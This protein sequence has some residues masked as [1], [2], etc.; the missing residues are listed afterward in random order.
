MDGERATRH[1]Y[2]DASAP[3]YANRRSPGC[4]TPAMPCFSPIHHSTRCRTGCR[5]SIGTTNNQCSVLSLDFHPLSHRLTTA[6]VDHDVKKLKDAIAMHNTALCSIG[7]PIG[8]GDVGV[9]GIFHSLH[10]KIVMGTSL[11]ISA[12][13][14]AIM[15]GLVTK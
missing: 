2:I 14:C 1:A 9:F 6:G 11:V 7:P 4:S 12:G 13:S 5:I 3:P 15:P 10:C 8:V